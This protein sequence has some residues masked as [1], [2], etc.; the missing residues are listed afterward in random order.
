MK[1]RTMTVTWTCGICN[2]QSLVTCYPYV[3]ATRDCDADPGGFEPRECTA[4]GHKI[5]SEDIDEL[6]YDKAQEW[7]EAAVEAKIQRRRD[8]E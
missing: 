1:N 2:A 5:K 7:Q 6:T 4:C 3:P 8:G